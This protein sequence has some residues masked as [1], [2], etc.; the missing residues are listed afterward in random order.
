MIYGY[1]NY[2]KDLWRRRE[3]LLKMFL[4]ADSA[5][6]KKHFDEG[7]LDQK[8]SVTSIA[9][10]TLDEFDLWFDGMYH[11]LDDPEILDFF[12][13]KCDYS[14]PI[15]FGVALDCIQYAIIDN[16]KKAMDAKNDNRT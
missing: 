1:E 5:S 12:E 4:S 2:M 6:L 10:S 16:R 13:K 14:E 11:S 7:L 3:E 9:S 15:T 8:D